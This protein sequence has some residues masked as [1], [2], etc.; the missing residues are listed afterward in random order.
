MDR[1][2]LCLEDG[3]LKKLDEIASERGYPSR[4]QA[5]ADFIRRAIVKKD[6]KIG[7]DCAGTVSVLYEVGNK[8]AAY[9]VEKILLSNKE[10]ICGMQ[11]VFLKDAHTILTIS[12]VGKPDK[13][14][15]I[16][17][18]LRSVKGVTHGSFSIVSAI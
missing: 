2:T 9:E 3:L 14:Q 15:N 11:K 10:N 8:D 12:V 5:V 13:L 17:D 18:S 16:A 7:K 6:W 1:F 4:S